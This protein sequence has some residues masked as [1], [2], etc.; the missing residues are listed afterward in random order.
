MAALRT[1]DDLGVDVILLVRG[2][3]SRADLGVFDSEWLGRTIAT[4]TTPVFTGIG[5]ETDRSV[6]D[7]VAHSAHKTPTAAASA[8]VDQARTARRQLDT[9]AAS[10][11]TAGAGRVLRAHNTL[12]VATRTTAVACRGH[13]GRESRLLEDRLVRVL[14]SAPLSVRAP[15]PPWR[16]TPQ[17][18][19]NAARSSRDRC[20]ERVEGLAALVSARDPG[21]LL[22]LGWSITHTDGGQLVRSRD[23]VAAGSTLVTTVAD[24]TIVS[25]VD[26]SSDEG[27]AS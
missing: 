24:G 2:G 13:L 20:A 11:A 4:L 18:V 15:A 6:A 21:H 1:A 19:A 5:H 9:A 14:D 8:L 17:R 12:G 10:V 23:D 7:E 16:Q 25:E 22:A 27:T 26:T 3:G